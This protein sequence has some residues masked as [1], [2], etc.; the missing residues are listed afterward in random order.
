M[1]QK[2]RPSLQE[3]VMFTFRITLLHWEVI[4]VKEM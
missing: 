4:N 1:A 3:V 2:A